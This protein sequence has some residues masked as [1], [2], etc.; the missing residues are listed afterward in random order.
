MAKI[1][2]VTVEEKR[3]EGR[4][5]LELQSIEMYGAT[6]GLSFLNNRQT[7]RR[8]DTIFERNRAMDDL[9]NV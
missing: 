2:T 5:L 8:T 4:Y 7:N 9:H 1:S 3:G 6:M